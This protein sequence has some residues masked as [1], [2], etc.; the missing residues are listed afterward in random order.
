M[1]H[2]VVSYD[3]S[4]DSKRSKVADI[5][6]GYGNRVQYSVFE[7]SLDGRSLDKLVAKLRPLAADHDTIRMYQLCA[8]CLKKVFVLG[9]EQA[10]GQPR[11]IV[12]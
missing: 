6:G 1:G 9:S 12:V 8:R 5:L 3:I 4:D 7:C 2:F 11:F 10:T